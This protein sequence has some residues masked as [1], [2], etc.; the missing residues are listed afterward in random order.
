MH[1]KETKVYIVTS[2]NYDDYSIKAVFLKKENAKKYL[3]HLTLL[4]E[5]YPRIEERF[6]A[7][8]EE[9]PKLYKSFESGFT[10]EIVYHQFNQPQ[11]KDFS[12]LGK[13]ITKLSV[14]ERKKLESNITIK[15][16]L[17]KKYR[18]TVNDDILGPLYSE[19]NMIKSEEEYI[20][21]LYDTLKEVIKPCNETEWNR[22][23]RLFF[24]VACTSKKKV[25]KLVQ[26]MLDS[27]HDFML[28]NGFARF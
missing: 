24:S 10:L 12:S 23:N 17:V 14:K 7:D 28:S 8:N 6:L 19:T 18:I 3:R 9:L 27:A 5:E 11:I 21:N 15:P 1:N 2:G 22:D 4:D 16:V 20:R 13:P 25:D 26:D